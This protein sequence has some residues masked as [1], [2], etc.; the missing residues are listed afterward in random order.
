MAIVRADIELLVARQSLL[1]NHQTPRSPGWGAVRR[2]Q[3][4]ARHCVA[5]VAL[6]GA[7]SDDKRL[8]RC[9]WSVALAR[10]CST[11]T[12]T[13]GHLELPAGQRVG[14]LGSSKWHSHI[15]GG[16]VSTTAGV[17]GGSLGFRRRVSG[18][19]PLCLLM[20]LWVELTMMM[21]KTTKSSAL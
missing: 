2:A 14:R 8:H 12:G 9:H 4:S 1:T 6:F 11:C 19:S 13:L 16:G 5:R 18:T 21:L 17:G 7:D 20:G 10:S 3:C 15:S